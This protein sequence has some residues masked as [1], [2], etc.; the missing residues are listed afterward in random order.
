MKN[1]VGQNLN[2]LICKWT[3]HL[4]NIKKRLTVNIVGWFFHEL[5]WN[6]PSSSSGKAPAH[7]ENSERED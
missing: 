6:R 2:Q 5:I 4:E 7:L 1:I 3:T